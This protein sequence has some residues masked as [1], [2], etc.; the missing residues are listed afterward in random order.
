SHPF[1]QHLATVFSAYQ[2]GPHPPPI[3]KYDGPTD[4]QTELISQNVDKLFRRL[5]D[6]EETLEGL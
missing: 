3:P 1:I 6:A 4:W 5:Y 2:V